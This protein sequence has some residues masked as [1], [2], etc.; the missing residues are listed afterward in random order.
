ML[1]G[2]FFGRVWCC[3]S[4]KACWRRKRGS[5]RRRGRRT[6]PTTALP[7]PCPGACRSCRYVTKPTPTTEKPTL[8]HHRHTFSASMCWGWYSMSCNARSPHGSAWYLIE[9]FNSFRHFTCANKWA[10]GAVTE[11]IQL[12]LHLFCHRD[13]WLTVCVQELCREI[14]HKI[15]VI[16][17]ERYNLEMKVNK[18]NKEVDW[19]KIV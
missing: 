7:C 6:W 2:C 8:T 18:S 1:S 5:K 10:A 19:M 9:I 16:D 15:D 14:H 17:E 4:P 13:M 12:T 3:Q 11:Q